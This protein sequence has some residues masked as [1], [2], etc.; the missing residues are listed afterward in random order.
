[1]ANGDAGVAA[2]LRLLLAFLAARDSRF[3]D[4]G[5]MK[6]RMAASGEGN[7]ALCWRW[8]CAKERQ[9]TVDER[10]SSICISKMQVLVGLSLSEDDMLPINL[11]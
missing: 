4:A 8:C 11:D 3:D 2:D 10:Q 9:N 7:A 1:M 5:G 6:L